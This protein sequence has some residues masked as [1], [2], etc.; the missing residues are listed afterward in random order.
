MERDGLSREAAEQRIKS[1]MPQEEKTKYADF[2]LDS[3]GDFENTRA[4][5]GTVFEQLRQIKT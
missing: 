3:S 2:L 4:Q 5:V 1:Q